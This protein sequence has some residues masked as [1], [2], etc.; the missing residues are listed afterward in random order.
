VVLKDEKMKVLLIQ[1]NGRHEQNRIYRECFCLQR[2]FEHHEYKADVWGLGHDGYLPYI[3]PDYESYDLIINLE[4]YDQTGWVPNLATVQTKKFLWSIDA[5]VKG[6]ES[7]LKTANEGNYDLILQATPEFCNAQ[8]VW[9]PNCYD[10]EVIKPLNLEK[11]YDVGF[12]GNIVNRA[13]LISIVANSFN[14]KLDEFVIGNDMV[15]A[16]NLYKVHWNANI[17]IDINYRNFETIGCGT[18]LLTSYNEHIDSLG[19]KDGENCLIYSNLEQ[20]VDKTKDIL[21]NEEK[22]KSIEQQG[23]KLAKQHTYKQRIKKILKLYK[24]E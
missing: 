12:C 2:A 16:I 13:Q 14:F 15:K 9:F 20:M 17:S 21:N 22:R 1:E 4:N 5:H 7:Y 6:I 23:L 8:S 3:Q 18:C 24:G 10:D 19:F 11:V